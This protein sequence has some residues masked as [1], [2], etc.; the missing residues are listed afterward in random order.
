MANDFTISHTITLPE[1]LRREG[2]LGEVV[3]ETLHKIGSDMRE[4][5]YRSV[6]TGKPAIKYN[7]R[8]DVLGR[9]LVSY[10]VYNKTGGLRVEIGS[11]PS[12]LFERGR[13]L[14][15][16][17]RQ[18][19][20]K[21]FSKILPPVAERIANKRAGELERKLARIANAP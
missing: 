21:V 9:S 8:K 13:R 17:R 2:I 6:F 10:K 18:P 19:G 7:R 16:G 4:Y 14:R 15:D 11:Y 20:I 5:L 1:F 3:G 12:H